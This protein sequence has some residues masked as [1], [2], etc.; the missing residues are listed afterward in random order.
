MRNFWKSYLENV[1]SRQVRDVHLELYSDSF[2]LR[3]RISSGLVVVESGA[4]AEGRKLLSA[5]AFQAGLETGRE[6]QE[7]RLVTDAA[8]LRI[9]IIP[10]E[11]GCSCV[12]R[13]LA[14]GEESGS[15]TTP[16]FSPIQS[17]V[18]EKCLQSPHG[19]ILLCGPT[20]SG[21]TTT[22]YHL[23]S[24]L[25]TGDKKIITVEDPVERAIEGIVQTEVCAQR[26]WTMPEALRRILRHDPDVIMLGEIR[27]PETADIASRAA[28]TGHK[29]LSTLHSADALGVVERLR[30][31]GVS[32]GVQAE[33]MELS[34]AQ[35]LL[36][37]NCIHCRQPNE[38]MKSDAANWRFGCSGMIGGGCIN[39]QFKGLA[40]TVMLA[41]LIHWHH[42]LRQYIRSGALRPE[43]TKKL[44]DQRFSGLPEQIVAR[45][46]AGDISPMVGIS[47]LM[48]LPDYKYSPHHESF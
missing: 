27:D 10:T 9:S 29:V 22:L 19:W 36:P 24:K 4:L 28:L 35:R 26:G 8:E 18:I 46:D 30:D 33:V 5:L 44:A 20:G 40:G 47:C 34:I 3:E 23:L 16:V 37:G 14:P 42:D 31:L 48:S 43:I 21:K 38:S 6:I 25:N 1:V 32:N 15:L 13:V 39:C 17:V 11:G 2:M 45:V 12:M 7:G 41:E